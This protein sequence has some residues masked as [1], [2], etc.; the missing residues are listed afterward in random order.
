M[1]SSR[2]PRAPG[3][4]NHCSVRR[5]SLLRLSLLSASGALGSSRGHFPLVPTMPRDLP[6]SSPSR[7]ME[8]P[9]LFWFSIS[10]LVLLAARKFV[11]PLLLPRPAAHFLLYVASSKAAVPLESTVAYYGRD[12]SPPTK[13]LS[14]PFLIHAA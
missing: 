1:R 13:A 10:S 2:A 14:A 4:H 3:T 11:L 6:P 5:V 7:G 12:K 9:P 8:E